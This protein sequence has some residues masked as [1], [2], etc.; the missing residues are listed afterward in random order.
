MTVDLHRI[1]GDGGRV[2]VTPEAMQAILSEV[3][4]LAALTSDNQRAVRQ[5]YENVLYCRWAGQSDDGRKRR[6][7]LG[8][9]PKPFEGASDN[10]I[11]LADMLV[12]EHEMEAVAAASRAIPKFTAME[13]GDG[14][15]PETEA[16][17][18]PDQWGVAPIVAAH[19]ETAGAVQRGGPAGAGVL[20]RGL[21]AGAGD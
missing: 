13:S 17:E 7:S 10:R 9:E 18:E 2:S 16:D 6:E 14:C 5:D 8:R 4:D 3:K 21:D 20:L 1:R 11:R 19:P 12:K 15:S